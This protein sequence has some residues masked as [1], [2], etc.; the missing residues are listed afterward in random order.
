MNEPYI[1]LIGHI[2]YAV[3]IC[4]NLIGALATTIWWKYVL[5]MSPLQL[6]PY[7]TYLNGTKVGGVSE[8]KHHIFGLPKFRS[9]YHYFPQIIFHVLS[10][11]M[12]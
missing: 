5:E 1:N 4:S 10:L 3:A 8:K 2:N 11:I 9:P 7:E 12:T 6:L